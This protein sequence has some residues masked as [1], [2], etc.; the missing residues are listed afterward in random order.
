MFSRVYRVLFA[1]CSFDLGRDKNII[2]AVVGP[3]FL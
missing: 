2:L 3:F 1:A